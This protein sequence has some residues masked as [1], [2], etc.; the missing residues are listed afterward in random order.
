M[1]CAET[2]EV[3]EKA[4]K[5]TLLQDSRRLT[6]AETIRLLSDPVFAT[7]FSATLASAPFQYFFWECPALTSSLMT[8]EYEHVV[9]AAPPF[10]DAD[11]TDFAEHFLAGTSAVSFPNLGGDSLLVAPVAEGPSPYPSYGSIAS[12]VRGA[13]SEAQIALWARVGETL[14][15]RL[16]EREPVWLSTE[17]S[18]VPWL[19]VRMDPR[20]KYYHWGP[21]RS[22]PPA[23]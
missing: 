11:P 4:V 14:S 22:N 3:D 13:S 7:F 16:S 20:P 10:R 18:A 5:V 21:Y 8:S 23:T 2:H 9:L 12:F 1:Y 19:H 6:N 17:G 15:R